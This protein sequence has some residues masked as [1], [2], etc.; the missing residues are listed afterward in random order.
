MSE[1]QHRMMFEKQCNYQ[2]RLQM[3]SF[4]FFF[5][6]NFCEFYYKTVSMFAG[7]LLS[8]IALHVSSKFQLSFCK[9]ILMFHASLHKTRDKAPE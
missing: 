3:A 6:Q 5:L 8:I 9:L 7:S 2:R 4:L 1:F